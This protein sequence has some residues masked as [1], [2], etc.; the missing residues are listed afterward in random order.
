M[1]RFV[2]HLIYI[3][4]IAI[5]ATSAIV[6]V[7]GN[8]AW[9]AALAALTAVAIAV[10]AIFALRQNYRK[11][12]LMLE[13]VTNNDFTM[14]FHDK[15][16]AFNQLLAN[17]SEIIRNMKIQSS[18]AE[19]YYQ[20]IIN[21]V[22]AGIFTLDSKGDVRLCNNCTL[23]LFGFSTFNNIVQLDRIDPDLKFCFLGMSPGET[24]LLDIPSIKTAVKVSVTMSSIEMNGS[25]IRIFA[26]NDIH[27]A[28]DKNELEAWSRLTRVLTHEIMNSVAPIHALSDNLLAD[29]SSCDGR[30]REKIEIIRNTAADLMAFTESYRKF[31]SIPKPQKRLVYVSELIAG[32]TEL[33]EDSLKDV[34][35]TVTSEPDNLIVNIDKILMDRVVV[36]LLRNAVEAKASKIQLKAT[37][38]VNDIVHIDISDNGIPIPDECREQIFVPFFSTKQ[39]GSGIGLA[40]TRRI[41]DLHDGS[42]SLAQPVRK[43]FTKTFRI[44]LR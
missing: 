14:R 9:L 11:C 37:Y 5:A 35:L 30:T 36:N 22:N 13:A 1:K 28:L 8:T 12:A 29:N 25:T 42:I 3:L 27:S 19:R 10:T 41:L 26:L 24:L 4:A 38:D 34:E 39:S 33:M 7:D 2:F 23:K 16:S 15:D 44:S 40:V 17:L 18:Q 31:S 32:A 43:P 6:L 21:Q 20:L